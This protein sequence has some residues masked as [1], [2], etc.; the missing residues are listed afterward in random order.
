MVELL[1]LMMVVDVM[2]HEDYCLRCNDMMMTMM[3]MVV[4]QQT[5]V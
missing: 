3:M 5:E 2:D 4:E 1:S